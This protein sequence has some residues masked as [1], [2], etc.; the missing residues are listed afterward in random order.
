MPAL[1]TALSFLPTDASDGAG[2]AS[3]AL[4]GQPSKLER[5]S[6]LSPELQPQLFQP[7]DEGGGVC[8]VPRQPGDRA[9]LLPML[10]QRLAEGQ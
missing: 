6:S 10:P 1:R 5:I 9:S 3:G 8:L 7:R 4:L 2:A